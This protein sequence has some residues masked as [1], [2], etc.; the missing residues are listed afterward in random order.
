MLELGPPFSESFKKSFK[1]LE[2]NLSSLSV[3]RGLTRSKVYADSLDP[4]WVVA[5]SNNRILVSG[6][7]ENLDMVTAVQ[8]IVDAGVK[9]GRRGFVIY[10]PSHIKN[11]RIGERIQGINLYPNLRNYYVLASEETAYSI[12]LP[13]KYRIEQITDAFLEI[14]YR[15]TEMVK[16]EMRSERVSVEDFLEKSFGFC[17]LHGDVIASWCMSEYNADNRFEIGI[18]T[19]PYYRRKGLAFQTAKACINY[20]FENGYDTVGW[21]CWVENESSNKLAL[22][23]GFKHFLKYP[24]E[25]LEIIN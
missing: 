10:Y 25:Y 18:E 3:I 2:H 14:G 8:K 1:S 19:H 22:S 16:C 9:A 23:L 17:A 12:D 4:I 20:G 21:H 7:F 13:H 15:N 24:V 6:D 11:T 5:Y